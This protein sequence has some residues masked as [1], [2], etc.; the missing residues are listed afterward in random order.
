MLL[1]RRIRTHSLRGRLTLWTVAISSVIQLML[2]TV[3]FFYQR[4]HLG[5]LLS[6]RIEQRAKFVADS[7]RDLGRE[8]SDADLSDIAARAMLFPRSEGWNA[9]VFDGALRLRACTRRPPITPEAIGFLNPDGSP[10]PRTARAI[11]PWLTVEG[12]SDPHARVTLRPFVSST[13]ERLWILVAMTD[14][15]FESSTRLTAQMLLIALPLGALATAAASWM[16][17]GAAI[18]PLRDLRRLAESFTLDSIRRDMPEHRPTAQEL[19]AFQRDLR[20]ARERLRQAFEAQDRFISNVSHE[21]K[22]PIAILLAEAQTLDSKS[23]PEESLRFTRSVVDEMRRLGRTV[24]SLMTLTNVR[25]GKPL[26]IRRR[27]NLNDLVVDSVA[28]CRETARRAQVALR[29]RL[30]DDPD[31]LVDGDAELLRALIENLLRSAIRF[32]RA[33]QR[34]DIEVAVARARCTVAV[35]DRG[36]QLDDQA[37]ESMFSGGG[38]KG[39]PEE[40]AGAIGLAIAQG[41]AELHGGRVTAA[42]TPDGGCVFTAEIPLSPA[43]ASTTAQTEGSGALAG[44]DG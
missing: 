21:I 25:G 42:N 37:L 17:A 24:E 41:I 39:E 13:G 30:A 8:P 44:A 12:D 27:C 38:S 6:E 43:A 5:Q 35:R 28:R 9:A 33:G 36:P 22:T 32:S 1:D 40:R 16:I 10:S 18:A 14:T 20:E 23:P 26:A 2:A 29:P 34:V 15:Y 3:V 11:V 7:L 31:P 19:E 4:Q